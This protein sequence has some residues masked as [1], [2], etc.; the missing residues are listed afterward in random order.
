MSP[1]TK[2][3][4]TI[5]DIAFGGEGV[6][7]LNGFVV[8]VPFVLPDEVVEAEIT[9]VKKKFARARLLRVLRASPDRVAPECRYFG[10]C[11]GCQYQHV[12][13]AAQLRIKHKQITDLFQRI[14][15]FAGSAIEPVVPCLQQYGYRNRIMVRSQWDKFKKG[16]NIGFIRHDNR[17]VLDIE[18]CKIAGPALN[19]Q[20]NRVR[21]EPPAKGGLKVAL[22]VAP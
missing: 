8:F 2:V 17:L 14:G 11:G 16:L 22:R 6:A 4:L 10:D 5:E 3:S 19:E 21:A 9:E 15:G 12:G 7:R 1:D 18:E 20:I 13:Y